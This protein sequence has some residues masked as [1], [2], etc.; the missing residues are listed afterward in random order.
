[1][2]ASFITT[3]AALAGSAFAAPTPTGGLGDLLNGLKVGDIT[4]EL[5]LNELPVV[6][7]LS[8]MTKILNLPS[9]PSAS[10]VPAVQSGHIVQDLGPQLDNILTVVGPDASTLLIELSPEV[11]DLVSGLGLGAL[12]APLGSIV[13]SASGLGDLIT[14]LGPVVDGLVTVIGADVGALLINL[15]PEVAGLVSGLGLPAIGVPV[16]TVVA[17]LG[18]NVKRGEII[19]DLAP[20]V[21]TTLTVTGENAKELLIELSPA[22]TSLVAGLGLKTI[23]GPVGSI[24]AEAASV[25]D[26]IKDIA[27]PVEDLLH[28]VGKDGKHLL[29]KLSPSVVHLVT[30]LGL[31]TVASPLGDILTTVA[32]NL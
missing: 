17:T 25:G 1:M 21:K 14:G 18:K 2:K 3:V 6:S 10:S 22:V 5:K 31:P 28:I 19:Q 15:S 12:G 11:T 4:K 9:T 26:L 16:G 30:G 8:D 29:I 32:Q 24:V 7:K 23:S 27:Q 20:K 13:A